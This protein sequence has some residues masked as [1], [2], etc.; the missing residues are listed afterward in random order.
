[1]T[2]I[3]SAAA[4]DHSGV[5]LEPGADADRDDRLAEGDQD[6][7]PVPLGEM[8]RRDPPAAPQTDHEWA[9]VVDRERE[10]PHGDARVS[11]EE[12]RDHEQRGAEQPG[13]REPEKRAAT[14]RIVA[15][16]DGR[17]NEMKEADEEVG[18][19]EQHSVVSES[20]RHRQGD[21]EH[22][23]HR[24]KHRQSD[25]ALV[26]VQ[27]AR[28]PCVTGPR[29]PDRRKDE[30]PVEHSAPSRVVRE[31]ARDLRDREHEDEVEEELERRDLV[32]VAVLEPALGVG[33]APRLE[34]AHVGQDV[35]PGEERDLLPAEPRDAS[36]LAVGAQARLLRRDLGAP[37]PQELADL[38]PGIH[39]NEGNAAPRTLGGPA[40]TWTK[41]GRHREPGRASVVVMQAISNRERRRNE[42]AK[43]WRPGSL[44]HRARLHGHELRLRPA[45]ATSRR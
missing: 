34:V 30:H 27:R 19:A 28:Q 44:G 3:P 42:N 13:R 14:V 12:A 8:L 41:R 32:L 24:G 2:T 25:A 11:L 10:H 31:Q 4:D 21:A 20:A 38:T 45:C 1:M 18:E 17:E 15:S 5:Q 35:D 22:R 23:R 9:E 26:D 7:Q 36:L 6:D 29:P 39:R 16:D 43:A 40:S 33:H 37:R